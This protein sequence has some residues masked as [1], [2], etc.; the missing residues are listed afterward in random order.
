[1]FHRPVTTA[2]CSALVLAVTLVCLAVL[3]SGA[4]PAEA[5]R[6]SATVAALVQ[7]V[8]ADQSELRQT[9]NEFTGEV[10]ATVGG[11]QY[12][13]LTRY[14]RGAAGRLRGRGGVARRAAE[15]RTAMRNAEQYVY[16]HLRAD[17]LD[18]VHYQDYSA[19]VSGR[20][21]IGELR[22]A[23]RPKE[24]VVIG[25]HLD[26]KPSRSRAPGADDNGASCAALL[27]MAKHFA[28]HRFART[29]HFVFFGGEEAGHLG[30]NAYA[31]AARRAGEELVAVLNADQYARSNA[32]TDVVALHTRPLA[33]P[34]AAQQDLW[35]ARQYLAA[36]SAYGISE[37]KPQLVSLGTTWSD[38]QSFWAQGY[39]ATSL[40]EDQPFDN[41]NYHTTADT[42]AHMTW[43]Y[44][45][46]ATQGLVATAAHLA[47]MGDM[48]PSSRI[49]VSGLAIRGVTT[50]AGRGARAT[51]R[52]RDVSFT[53]VLGAT[54]RGRFTG[55]SSHRVSGLT[56]ASG[57]VQLRSP[58]RARGGVWTF[59]VTGVSKSG[60]VY[61]G[62]LNSRTWVRLR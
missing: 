58:T 43:P 53:T 38:H 41:P 24:I 30:S 15:S 21:V 54:V 10:P 51:V 23:T 7:A 45:V 49:Y 60:W 20:N 57:E 2:C 35:I 17:G 55:A 1:M 52:V 27:W 36:A 8:T 18:A 6:R 5:L 11:V 50:S 4:R 34:W 31:V 46:H 56:N 16:E 48:L 25:A 61:A 14:C 29:I 3:A 13:F 39:G 40:I 47:Y 32:G 26:D 12:T 44:Y 42:V 62:A 33:G 9:L 22:G 59:T 37:L 28:G 19:R